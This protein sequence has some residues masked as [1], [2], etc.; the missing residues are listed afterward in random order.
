M[1]EPKHTPGPWHVRTEFLESIG[2]TVSRVHTTADG[3]T[4]ASVYR[5]NNAADAQLIAAAPDMLAAL[6]AVHEA[7]KAPNYGDTDTT[8]DLLFD[9][10]K[11]VGAAIAKATQER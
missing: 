3:E 5:N 10:M 4:L 6:I 11:S 2:V 8:M 1:S 9:A 7:W